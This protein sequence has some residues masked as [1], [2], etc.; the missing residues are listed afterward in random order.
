MQRIEQH[1]HFQFK[2][3]I[4][5]KDQRHVRK[6]ETIQLPRT[7]HAA[8]YGSLTVGNEVH[9]LL[10]FR[11]EVV[12]FRHHQQITGVQFILTPENLRTDALV[13][14]VRPLVGT[15][16]HDGFIQPVMVVARAQ[17][18]YQLITGQNFNIGK[19]RNLYF[20][21]AVTIVF[22][23]QLPQA[24][25]IPQDT[26]LL[27]LTHYLRQVHLHHFQP[28]AFQGIGKEGRTLLLPHWRQLCRIA[29]QQQTASLAG[30]DKLHQVV[31]QPA[32]A[33]H[34]TGQS[35]IGNHRGLIHYIESVS[36]QIIVHRKIAQLVGER[37]LSI[38]FFMNCKRRMPRIR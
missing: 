21:Q 11:P 28:V 31:Q 3:V 35:P 24:G 6:A 16:H 2:V 9:L 7:A 36:C 34:G 27:L 26:R 20:W 15:A 29:H 12:I 22:R 23:Y 14:D 17:R 18:F 4:V 32:R 37:L 19:P 33:E 1:V 10:F 38:N 30:I 25:G 13:V 8:H 5:R